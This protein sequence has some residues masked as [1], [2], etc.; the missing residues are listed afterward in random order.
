MVGRA[1]WLAGCV[2]GRAVWLA[3]SLVSPEAGADSPVF[4]VDSVQAWRPTFRCVASSRRYPARLC[5]PRREPAG[6]F[7]FSGDI[8]RDGAS[9]AANGPVSTDSAVRTVATVQAPLKPP[10]PADVS[11][12]S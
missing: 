2:V 9:R 3:G 6:E 4:W 12:I 1:V 11:A 7:R 5:K 8:R 10:Q